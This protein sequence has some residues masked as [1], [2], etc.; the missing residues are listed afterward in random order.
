MSYLSGLMQAARK[1][2]ER[3]TEVVPETQYQSLQHF[4][5]HSPWDYR[6]VMDQ[7]AL[8]ADWDYRGRGTIGHSRQAKP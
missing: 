5:T 2:V 6:P 7:V 1:N 4:T 8:D 3:M